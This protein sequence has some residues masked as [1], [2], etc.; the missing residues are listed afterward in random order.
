MFLFILYT[1]NSAGEGVFTDISKFY[2]LE[3]VIILF[4]PEITIIW[5][6][7]L[8]HFRNQNMSI[9]SKKKIFYAMLL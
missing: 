7:R 2:N 8:L 4:K 5:V 1:R 3:T 9:N 6:E